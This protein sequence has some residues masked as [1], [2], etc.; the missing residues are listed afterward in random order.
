MADPKITPK[1]TE[2]KYN[3]SNTTGPASNL[4]EKPPVVFSG[5]NNIPGSKDVGSF[6]ELKKTTNSA[7]E[8]KT[9]GSPVPTD[10]YKCIYYWCYEGCSL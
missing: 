6:T 10:T 7:P 2:K 4:S 9:S 5:F 8:T 1:I 3:P